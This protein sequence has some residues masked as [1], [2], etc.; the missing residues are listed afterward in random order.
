MP[1]MFHLDISGKEINE[2]QLKNVDSISLAQLVFHLDRSG[3]D[4]SDEQ[5]PK[6]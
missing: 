2:E 4:N 6:T 1:F 5:L 3:N